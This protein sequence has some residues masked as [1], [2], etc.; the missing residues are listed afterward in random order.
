MALACVGG[1]L[2]NIGPSLSHSCPFSVNDDATLQIRK[3]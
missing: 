3:S 1:S 2:L